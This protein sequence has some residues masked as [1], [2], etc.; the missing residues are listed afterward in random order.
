MTDVP[1]I[2]VGSAVDTAIQWLTTHAGG[3]FDAISAVLLSS[4]W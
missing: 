1:T 4:S 3:L 2:P